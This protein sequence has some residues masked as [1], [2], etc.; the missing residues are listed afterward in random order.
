MPK[1]ITIG[2]PADNGDIIDVT[3]DLP[4]GVVGLV[5]ELYGTNA[6][7]TVNVPNPAFA[8]ALEVD[9]VSNPET[10]PNPVRVEEYAARKLVERIIGEV[11]NYAVQKG[12]QALAVTRESIRSDIKAET[13]QINV[14]VNIT[15]AS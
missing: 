5:P 10:I 1:Q 11:E 12:M 3:V 2:W 4:D 14:S 15:P 8:P 7:Y 6:G 13:D 9:P